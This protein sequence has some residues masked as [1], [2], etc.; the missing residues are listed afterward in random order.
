MKIGLK[1]WSTNKHYLGQAAALYK[2]GL[3]DYVE[4]FYVPGS[5]GLLSLWQGLGAPFI[6][7]APHT[8]EGLNPADPNSFDSNLKLAQESFFYAERLKAPFVIFHPGMEGSLDEAAR[9]ISC[10]GDAARILI[11][12]KPYQSIR[13]ARLLF[14]GS[15]PQEIKHLIDKTKAGF[16]LDMGHAICAANSLGKDA[17]GFIDEFIALAP[18]IYHMSDGDFSSP[19]DAHPNLG[20]G[21]YPLQR[22]ADRIGRNSVITIETDKAYSDTLRDFEADVAY[23]RGLYGGK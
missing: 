15:T 13:D 22:L 6:I 1:L 18:K 3:C 17:F 2:K 21:N 16:C 23:L 8:L 9:Q 12:N 10:F 14:R 5:M 19:I 4:L 7:H 11:E 20:K